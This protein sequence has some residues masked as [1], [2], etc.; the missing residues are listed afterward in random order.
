MLALQIPFESFGALLLGSN[1]CPM[2]QNRRNVALLGG[3]FLF[4]EEQ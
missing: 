4:G 2:A 1:L 3:A